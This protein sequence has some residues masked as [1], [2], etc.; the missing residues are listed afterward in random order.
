[1]VHRVPDVRQLFKVQLARIVLAD[2]KPDGKKSW[3]QTE[4]FEVQ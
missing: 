4:D 1:M 3:E 2:A